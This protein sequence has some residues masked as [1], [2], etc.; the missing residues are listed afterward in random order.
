MTSAIEIK[1][2]HKYFGQLE[3]L[4]GI[5]FRVAMGEV[6]CVI[7]PSGSGKST[8]LRLMIRLEEAAGGSI[9]FEGRDIADYPPERLRRNILYVQ[10]TPTVTTGTVRENLLLHVV[11][12]IW[13]G[14]G[15][16]AWFS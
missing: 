6:V 8:L 3:V 1:G 15:R 14:W 2:L 16:C 5:D 11:M 9:R 12:A 13:C 10:Q 7:G 4:R